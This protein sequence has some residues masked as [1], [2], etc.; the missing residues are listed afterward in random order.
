MASSFSALVC[1][2]VAVPSLA[3]CGG[4]TLGVATTV[5]GVTPTAFATIPPVASTL[6]GTTTTLPANAVGSE[7]TYTIVAG[8]SPIS[9]A[10]KFGITVSLLLSYNAILVPSDFPYPGQTLRIPANATQPVSN[11]TTQTPAGGSTPTQ[12]PTGPVG[13]GCG[14]RPAGTYEVQSGD[15]MWAITK[16]FCITETQLR[17][18][19]EWATGPVT[20]LIGQKINIPAA[21]G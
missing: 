19:N 9:V 6:P 17:A 5:V 4:D 21:N 2:A 3:A 7:T 12:T 15:S 16:K 18:A 11:G 14:T 20:F 8:D 10:T 1:V 13:P